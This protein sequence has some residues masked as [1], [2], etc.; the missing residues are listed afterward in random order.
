[1]T[2]VRF[3]E[4][5]VTYSLILVFAC[6]CVGGTRQDVP[7]SNTSHSVDPQYEKTPVEDI[8][9]V[10]DSREQNL[11]YFDLGYNDGYE[12]GDHLE[13][14]HLY[15]KDIPTEWQKE[16]RKGYFAGYA[17]GRAAADPSDDYYTGNNNTDYFDL[18]DDTYE[19]DDEDWS[20]EEDW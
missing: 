15:K 14:G 3:F 20:D 9:Q 10:V 12:D 2:K 8:P 13:K 7:Y 4:I 19:G 16:Y 6:S 5:H 11:D 18:S 1:M 17:D